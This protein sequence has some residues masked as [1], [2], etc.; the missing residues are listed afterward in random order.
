[1]E[2]TSFLVTGLL[3]WM[4]VVSCLASFGRESTIGWNRW[5]WGMVGCGLAVATA[6]PSGWAMGLM[7]CLAL[8]AVHFTNPVRIIRLY[9]FPMLALGA[10][11]AVLAPAMTV[12]MVAPVLWAVVA[13]T[14]AT[15]G[16]ALVSLWHR[17][18]YHLRLWPCWGAQQVAVVVGHPEDGVTLA[19]DPG[20]SQGY[21]LFDIPQVCIRAGQ[22]NANHAQAMG[23][24]GTAAACGLWWMGQWW[25]LGALGVTLLPVLICR[26]RRSS[27]LT[28]GP[29]YVG[30]VGLM[31]LTMT[32]LQDG[33]PAW[34]LGA[35]WSVL[36]AAGLWVAKPW[37][38]GPGWYDGDRFRV[39][40][41]MV[42][43][44]WVDPPTY[45]ATTTYWWWYY[46]LMGYGIGSW[47]TL[48]LYARRIPP[49]QQFMTPAH[50]EY[51]ALLIE[52]GV[53]G[54]VCAL[55]FI[56]TAAWRLAH[57]GPEA[58]AV[59][60]VGMTLCA[61]ATTH[62][63]WTFPQGI[64]K[65]TKEGYGNMGLVMLSFVVALLTEGFR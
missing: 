20:T 24:V 14:V 16:W 4:V 41:E 60:L 52:R 42:Q 23:V 27:W 1:M 56:G 9:F 8:G 11:Y 32:A 51:V 55:G 25:A 44:Y 47:E 45:L 15:G 26:D 58:Q 39:W 54:L 64:T 3:V 19:S 18:P 49:T 7:A 6:M 13:V 10:A 30:F 53:V 34:R 61:I 22:G 46:R 35:E 62:F 21:F 48:V 43:R 28:Q 2:L 59:L 65:T 33:A 5:H 38:R 29:A 57:G 17:E 31:L 50:N 12:A 37:S 63:P 36:V 40:R